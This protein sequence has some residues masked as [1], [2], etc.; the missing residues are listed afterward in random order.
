MSR[1]LQAVLTAA[2]LAG[3]LTG[4]RANEPP[5]PIL[6]VSGVVLLEGQP[7]NGA[8]VRFIPLIGHG[9]EYVATGVTDKDGRFTLTCK[10]QPGA[11]EGENLVLIKDEVPKKLQSENLKVQK[12][13]QEYWAK[14]GGRPLPTRYANLAES[15]LTATVSPEQKEFVF[16]MERPDTPDGQGVK[17]P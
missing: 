16:Q 9:P 17:T 8:H 4:C 7:V 13:L 11:C 6:E 5:P 15:P 12:E 10:G 3:L 14:L 1:R 2:A